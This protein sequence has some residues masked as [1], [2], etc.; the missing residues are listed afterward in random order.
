MPVAS[1][2]FSLVPS[3][4]LLPSAGWETQVTVVGALFALRA[5]NGLISYFEAAWLHPVS[6][7]KRQEKPEASVGPSEVLRQK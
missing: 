2:R 5:K 1:Q 4:C 7:W 3:Q 6:N